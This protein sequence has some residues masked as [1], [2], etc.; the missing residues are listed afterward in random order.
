MKKGTTSHYSK[1]PMRK[2][3]LAKKGGFRSV[4]TF[5]KHRREPANYGK[6]PYKSK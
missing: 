5:E 1:K 2:E 3:D 4:K 6:H